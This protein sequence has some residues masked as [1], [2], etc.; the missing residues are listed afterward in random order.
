[1]KLAHLE[2][3]NVRRRTLAQRYLRGLPDWL[4]P[5]PSDGVFHLFVVQTRE[6][7]ALKAHLAQRGV[8]TDIHYP[9]PAHQQ[10]PY[11]GFAEGALPRTERLAREVLSLPLYPELAEQDVDYV[12]DQI[13]SFLKNGA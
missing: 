11:R 7:D 12:L 2:I 9:L 6:R 13:R 4:A 3:W 8:A 1:V 5:P 10:Q